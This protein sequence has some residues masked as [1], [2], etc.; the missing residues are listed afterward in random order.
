[1]NLIAQ[2]YWFNTNN[3]YGS[4]SNTIAYDVTVAEGDGSI[5]VTGTIQ[6]GHVRNKYFN[7]QTDCYVLKLDPNL[8]R[9]YAKSFGIQ[10]SGA[11]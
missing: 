9:I 8:N 2:K 6:Y 3:A 10:S 11:I 5:Y 7:A 4:G 1:M